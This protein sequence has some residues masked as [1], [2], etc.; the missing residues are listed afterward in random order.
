MAHA[1]RV[2]VSPSAYLQDSIAGLLITHMTLATTHSLYPKCTQQ[3][4]YAHN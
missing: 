2:R 1:M 3:A 4:Y